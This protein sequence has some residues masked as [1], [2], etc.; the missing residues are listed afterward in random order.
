M[1]SID[2]TCRGVRA[3]QGGSAVSRLQRAGVLRT[4]PTQ[5]L[6]HPSPPRSSHPRINHAT[7]HP[8]PRLNLLAVYNPVRPSVL[9]I[10]SNTMGEPIIP[11]SEPPLPLHLHA[12]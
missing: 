2:M 3:I 8:T 11:H 10:L 7:A 5:R 1:Q 12:N 9:C 6:P 4:F